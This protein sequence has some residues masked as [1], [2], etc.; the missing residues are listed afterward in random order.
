MSF[1]QQIV[2]T[3]KFMKAYDRYKPSS[4][5]WTDKTYLLRNTLWSLDSLTLSLSER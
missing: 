1:Q 3:N 2:R 4:N 5:P